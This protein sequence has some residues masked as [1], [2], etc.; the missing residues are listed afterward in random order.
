MCCI[1]WPPPP[2]LRT[3]YMEAPLDLPPLFLP[4]SEKLPKF[5]LHN[6]WMQSLARPRGE[7]QTPPSNITLAKVCPLSLQPTP[8]PHEDNFQPKRNWEKK[9]EG[10]RVRNREIGMWISVTQVRFCDSSQ[11]DWSWLKTLTHEV[12]NESEDLTWVDSN[13][14]HSQP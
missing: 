6:G 9:E 11:V 4:P 3:S 1:S 8:K 12:V 14:L 5:K 2:S 13:W 10:V 7:S